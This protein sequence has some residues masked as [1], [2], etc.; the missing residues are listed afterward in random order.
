MN[1][2]NFFKTVTGFVA[3]VYAACVPKAKA[4]V[5]VFPTEEKAR[6]FSDKRLR[7]KL[8]D[9]DVHFVLGDDFDEA[10]LLEPKKE[11]VWR[12]YVN[13]KEVDS[14]RAVDELGALHFP[15][16]GAGRG[17]VCIRKSRMMKSSVLQ[18]K[19]D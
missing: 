6:D 4:D 1:R 14:K 17:D 12:F 19:I 8:R 16:P 18:F 13:G 10:D 15:F 5:M 2:R 11:S 7:P 3:G 9:F